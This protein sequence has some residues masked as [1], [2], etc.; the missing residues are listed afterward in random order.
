VFSQEYTFPIWDKLMAAAPHDLVVMTAQGAAIERKHRKD[1]DE[2]VKAAARYMRIGQRSVPVC[3]LPYTMASE[4][5]QTLAGLCRGFLTRD[6]G[7]AGMTE[8]E[9]AACAFGA[10]YY[11]T[12]EHR[13]FSLR[14]LPDGADVAAIA[15]QYGGGGHRHAAGFRVFRSH[16]LAMA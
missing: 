16:S 1:I 11:D 8:Q 15:E 12:A 4:A 9:A 10:T 13:C 3:N 6:A 2:L 5:G 14:S 7:L